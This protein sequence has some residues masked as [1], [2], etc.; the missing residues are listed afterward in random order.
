MLCTAALF[1]FGGGFS[2]SMPLASRFLRL[3]RLL[4]FDFAL[5]SCADALLGGAGEEPAFKSKPAPLKNGVPPGGIMGELIF[6]DGAE[7]P[8]GCPDAIIT[9]VSLCDTAEYEAIS[10][11]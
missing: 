10:Q 9:N 2:G 3:S 1:F 7:E 8:A 6:D 5:S 11:C 4:R